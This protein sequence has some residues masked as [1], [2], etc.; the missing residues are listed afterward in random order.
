[1]IGEF[2]AGMMS[3]ETSA[4]FVA[5]ETRK[6]L[7]IVLIFLDR[8]FAYPKIVSNKRRFDGAAAGNAGP[9]RRSSSGAHK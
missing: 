3:A 5:F 9:E 7:K 6:S 4:S 2:G 8:V 1:M